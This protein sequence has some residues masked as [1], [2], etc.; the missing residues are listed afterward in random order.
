MSDCLERQEEFKNP[1]LP[2]DRNDDGDDSDNDLIR[3]MALLMA[4]LLPD[5]PQQGTTIL[6]MATDIYSVLTESRRRAE[7]H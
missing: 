3:Q 2:D 6:A 4:G 7:K 5:N 1:A